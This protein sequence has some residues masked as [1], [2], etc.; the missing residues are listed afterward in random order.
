[1]LA[2]VTVDGLWLRSQDWLPHGFSRAR[3]GDMPGVKRRVA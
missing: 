2:Q 1:V 3:C